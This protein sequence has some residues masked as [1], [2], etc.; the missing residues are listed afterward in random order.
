MRFALRSLL[1]TPGFTAIAIIALALGIGANTAIFS[2]VNTLFL[3]PLPYAEPDRL[4]ILQSSLPEKDIN[5]FGFSY[6]RFLA[7]K[8]GQQVFSDL[9][10]GIFTG[11]TITGGG[12]PEQVQGIQVSASY[13]TTLGVQP[14]HGRNFSA[15]EDRPGGAARKD[16]AGNGEADGTGDGQGCGEP[17]DQHRTSP[18][19]VL[20]APVP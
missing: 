20:S 7:V 13:L 14:Q 5:E 18:R 12:E 6:P 4:V 17:V 1:R 8:D 2:I 10:L 11:F 15:D 16:Q 19:R 3:R 9:A